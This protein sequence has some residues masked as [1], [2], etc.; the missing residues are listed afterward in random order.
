MGFFCLGSMWFMILSLLCIPKPQ[1]LVQNASL[2]QTNT[3]SS[4]NFPDFQVL[5]AKI[6]QI[7][8]LQP[9]LRNPGSLPGLARGHLYSS[10]WGKSEFMTPWK[11]LPGEVMWNR[12]TNITTSIRSY[13]PWWRSCN[14]RYSFFLFSLPPTLLVKIISMLSFHPFF[15]PCSASNLLSSFPL[16]FPPPSNTDR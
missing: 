5:F 4:P 16:H 3:F 2:Q 11:S 14:C 12:C 15:W 6:Q 13:C 9:P 1:E 7:M 10:S 8:S